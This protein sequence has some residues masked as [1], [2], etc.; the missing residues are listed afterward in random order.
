MDAIAVLWYQVVSY[1]FDSIAGG[2][3]H[4]CKN[5]LHDTFM[6]LVTKIGGLV[7]FVW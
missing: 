2:M 4:I 6:S 5:Q 7:Y 1:H 3:R